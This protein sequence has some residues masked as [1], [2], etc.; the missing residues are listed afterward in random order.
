MLDK[1]LQQREDLDKIVPS[2]MLGLFHLKLNLLKNVSKPTCEHLLELVEK[3]MVKYVSY[4]D[5]FN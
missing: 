2:Q 3:T 5:I 4:I 1:Y